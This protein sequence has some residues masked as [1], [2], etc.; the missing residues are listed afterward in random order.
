MALFMS[1]MI[2]D[3]SYIMKKMKINVAARASCM[4]HFQ[5]L[6][7]FPAMNDGK[8]TSISVNG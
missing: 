6:F 8:R 7:D 2:D 4:I 3:Y 1:F 5:S